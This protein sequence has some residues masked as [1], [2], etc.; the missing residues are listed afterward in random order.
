MDLE[1][2]NQ[3]IETN[4]CIY[5]EL[6]INPLTSGYIYH[7]LTSDLLTPKARA[8]FCHIKA[9]Q[10]HPL[11]SGKKGVHVDTQMKDQSYISNKKWIDFFKTE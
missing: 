2:I 4:W 6:P 7:L 8:G 10:L 1:M 5:Q 3:Q 9:F 11:F